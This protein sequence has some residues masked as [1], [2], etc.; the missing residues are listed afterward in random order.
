MVIGGYYQLA[1]QSDT[2]EHM[3]KWQHQKELLLQTRPNF[4]I[5]EANACFEYMKD[6][7]NFVTEYQQTSKLEK[8]LSDFIGVKH[9]VMT[10]SGS[11]ALIMA[12]LGANIGSGDDVIV[13]NYTMIATINAVKF[14]G[15]NP[16]IVDVDKRSQTITTEIIE[17]YRTSN[18]KCVIH[19]SLNNRSI[20][21]SGIADYC[22][23]NQIILIEDAAQSL[24]ATV[25]G[26]HYGTFGK[27]GCFSLSTPK[28]ISTGQGGFVVTDD[29]HIASKMSMIKNFGRKCGGVDLFEVFGL[30]MKFTDIQ[31]VIGIEQVKKLP[32]R[33]KFMRSLY[34]DYY[35][36]LHDLPIHMIAPIDDTYL[37]WF[38]DI[39]TPRRDELAIF[40]KAHNIQ[41]RPTYPEIHRTPMYLIDAEYP[42]TSS[43]SN[44]GL[45][46][47]SHTLLKQEDVRFICR[48]IRAFFTPHIAEHK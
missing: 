23:S 2:V 13:P 17:S 35:E 28:I 48:L 16:I 29:D 25:N 44:T 12:L 45:F 8:M 47:P 34:R 32:D 30:N 43:I 22:L 40:L 38:I 24:G 18:T 15:A 7:T 10:T 27:I 26:K 1:N 33:V 14:V 39:Y 21:L 4:D 19:V 5:A 31:A 37:P 9:V 6:G 11:M 3:M 20:D 42:I 41:T 46:L 36:Q